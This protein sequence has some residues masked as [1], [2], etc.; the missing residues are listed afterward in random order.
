MN[1]LRRVF[2]SGVGEGT[3]NTCRGR[4]LARLKNFAANE[5]FAVL[6]ILILGDHARARMGAVRIAQRSSFG[7]LFTRVRHS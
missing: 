1:E 6:S 5:A 2:A 4:L 3:V 7:F